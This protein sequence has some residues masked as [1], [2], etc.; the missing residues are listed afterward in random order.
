MKKEIIIAQDIDECLFNSVKKH[1]QELT[2]IGKKLGWTN[3]PTYEEVCLLGGTHGAYGKQTGYWEINEEMRNSSEFNQGL[4]PIEGSLEALTLLQSMLGIYLTTR[5]ENLTL[6]T[7]EELDEAGFPKREVVCRPKSI[8]L[9]HT[10]E[11]KLDVLRYLAQEKTAT[12]IDDSM[13]L[14]NAILKAN[15]PRIET[16]L[17]Q[18]PMTPKGKG[19]T[20]KKIREELK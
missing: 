10:T 14:H 17:F 11:W 16:V 19:K 20:W 1:Y 5:P 2:K 15:D 18:G 9:E 8:P 6:I 3:L 4:E 7:E 12:M 13:S